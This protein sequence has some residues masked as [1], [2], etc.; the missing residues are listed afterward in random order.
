M[1][2]L[3]AYSTYHAASVFETDKGLFFVEYPFTI[4]Q[5]RKISPEQLD[6]L[7]HRLEF[8]SCDVV[9]QDFL[10]LVAFVNQKAEAARA[11]YA[12]SAMTDEELIIG[13]EAYPESSLSDLL[14]DLQVRYLTAGKLAE[15]RVAMD[16]YWRVQA[17][18]KNRLLRSKLILM[19][20]SYDDALETL[21]AIQ[22]QPSENAFPTAYKAFGDDLKAQLSGFTS[23][24]AA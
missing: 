21:K 12:S 23:L 5:V 11:Q 17:I 15:A 18:A 24:A 3:R 13:L 10:H 1:L 19:E 7:V 2:R 14:D 16:R 22:K 6:Y 4:D 20:Q 9:Q 8:V